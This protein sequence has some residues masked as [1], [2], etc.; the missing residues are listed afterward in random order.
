MLNII[1]VLNKTVHFL[2]FPSVVYMDSCHILTLFGSVFV[3]ITLLKILFCLFVLV[4]FF[5]S[6]SI[7]Q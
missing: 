1:F 5:D 7:L 2:L 6:Q 4:F 3:E